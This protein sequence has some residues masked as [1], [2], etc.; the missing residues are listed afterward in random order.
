MASRILTYYIL[1]TQASAPDD[2]AYVT[3]VQAT[4]ADTKDELE[5]GLAVPAEQAMRA[6]PNPAQLKKEKQTV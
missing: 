4:H 5:D 6:A 1:T 3:P 2:A